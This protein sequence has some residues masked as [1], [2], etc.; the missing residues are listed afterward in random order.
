M[1]AYGT[2]LVMGAVADTCEKYGIKAVCSGPSSC[3]YNTN[4]CKITPLSTACGGPMHPLSILLCNGKGP[5]G[6]PKTDGMFGACKYN[7]WGSCG[8]VDG[9]WGVQGKDF[10]SQADKPFFA[11][12]TK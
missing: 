2:R 9:S 1:V 6:C 3:S 12:C 5:G 11:Y 10:V 8:A 7:N 4:R